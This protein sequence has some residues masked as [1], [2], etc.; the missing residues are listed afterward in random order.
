MELNFKTYIGT[1]TVKAA[2]MVAERAKEA[3]ANVP[4]MYLDITFAS[5]NPS[6]S[7]YLVI[8]SDGY[9]SW[10]PAKVFEESYKV[11][12]THVDRMKIE[13]EEL[14]ARICKA[15]MAIN[16]FGAIPENER[17]QLQEQMEVM[18]KYA[19][20]LYARIRSIVEPKT[21]CCDKATPACTKGTMKGD[22]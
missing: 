3:G 11:S 2:P 12:E 16:T 20:I 13:L 21:D 6:A 5:Y 15:T 17:W 18:Q 9:R 10:S 8:Y 1:K 14:N 7:G 19:D 4:E 22:E